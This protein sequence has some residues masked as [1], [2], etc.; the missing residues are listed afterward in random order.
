MGYR[1]IP[2]DFKRLILPAQTQCRL[3]SYTDKLGIN[4]LTQMPKA[5]CA[6][7]DFYN[8]KNELNYKEMYCILCKKDITKFESSWA[9][10]PT[11]SNNSALMPP[12]LLQSSKWLKVS[13]LARQWQVRSVIA[14]SLVKHGN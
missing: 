10:K 5:H 7:A 11:R 13:F 2:F 12:A 1:F 4:G 6:L 9:I 3:N 8:T 14:Y